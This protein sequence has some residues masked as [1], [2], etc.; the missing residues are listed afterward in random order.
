MMEL[1]WVDQQWCLTVFSL[2]KGTSPHPHPMLWAVSALCFAMITQYWGLSCSYQL[3][4]C[5]KTAGWRHT[6]DTKLPTCWT[7]TRQT[8]SKKSEG[9]LGVKVKDQKLSRLIVWSLVYFL[10]VIHLSFTPAA[11]HYQPITHLY[12]IMSM[13]LYCVSSLFSSFIDIHFHNFSN[14]SGE[15]KLEW[16]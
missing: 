9:P 6:G 8:H 13:L 3:K 14:S 1:S 2:W 4:C 11:F 7:N 10:P 12:F 16:E 5:G 15:C